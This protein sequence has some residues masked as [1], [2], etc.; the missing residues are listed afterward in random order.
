MKKDIIFM[1]NFFSLFRIKKKVFF[2][3]LSFVL[4]IFNLRSNELNR[5]YDLG[6]RG[7]WFCG[8]FFVCMI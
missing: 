1:Y 3:K 8:Y 5:V 2:F 6:V 7:F 4:L